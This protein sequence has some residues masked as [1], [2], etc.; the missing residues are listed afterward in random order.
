M[1]KH[2]INR[3]D[4]IRRT[5]AVSAGAL[6][7]PNLMAT[8]TAMAPETPG[9]SPGPVAAQ[10]AAVAKSIGPTV[11]YLVRIRERMQKV[12]FLTGDPLYQLVAKAEDVMR[13]LSMELHYR[14]CA[15]GVGR[16]LE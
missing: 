1:T 4:F 3:R 12:G 9:G 13:H 8:L 11:G 10:A 15:G 14:S 7:A 6:S 2:R 16:K 5:A